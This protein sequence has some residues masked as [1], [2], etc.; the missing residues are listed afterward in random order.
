MIEQNDCEFSLNGSPYHP[1][2]MET[3]FQIDEL[4]LLTQNGIAETLA[5][6]FHDY[7][8]ENL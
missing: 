6:N 5:E 1:A 7:E 2:F 4:T 3:G 8:G